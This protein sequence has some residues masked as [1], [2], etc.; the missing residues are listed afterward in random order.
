MG[1]VRNRE[2]N[3]NN[4]Q[5]VVLAGVR[6]EQTALNHNLYICQNERTFRPSRYVAFYKEGM[7]RYLFELTDAP[8]KK[9][10]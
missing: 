10:Q 9:L 5:V 4:N 1:P 7:I 6:A 2:W 8:Y 3:L